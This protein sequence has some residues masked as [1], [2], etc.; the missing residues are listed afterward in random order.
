VLLEGNDQEFSPLLADVRLTQPALKT[1]MQTVGCN[2]DEL[3]TDLLKCVD[4]VISSDMSQEAVLGKLR[5]I[6]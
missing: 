2:Q 6:L 4:L 3:S 5:S 1:V